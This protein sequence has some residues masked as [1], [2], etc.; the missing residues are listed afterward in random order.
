MV[1]VG[2]S[3][4]T[5]TPSLTNWEPKSHKRSGYTGTNAFVLHDIIQN[6]KHISGSD[7][8]HKRKTI[9]T[10]WAGEII[11]RHSQVGQ[12]Q[13]NGLVEKASQEV[14]SQVRTMLLALPMMIDD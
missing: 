14:E 1:V 8:N 13:S 3:A 10:K 7:T 9:K 4:S 12:S 5:R 2:I 11:P 6:L